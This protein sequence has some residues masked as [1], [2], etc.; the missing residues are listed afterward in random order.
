MNSCL[1]SLLIFLSLQFS[2]RAD[3]GHVYNYSKNGADWEEECHTGTEQSP[4][5]I[6]TRT[7]VKCE[8]NFNLAVY[9]NETNITSET[10]N[11]GTTFKSFGNW[12][13][14]VWDWNSTQYFFD[15][16]QFHFHAPSEHTVNG[17][18]FDGEIHLVHTLRKLPNITYN[19]T[20]TYAVLGI[21]LKINDTAGDHPFFKE[22]DPT[23]TGEFTLNM[24]ALEEIWTPGNFYFYEGGLTTPGCNEVVNWFVV[25]TPI[26]VS[27]KQMLKFQNA[28]AKNISFAGGNGNNRVTMPLNGREVM[29]GTILNGAEKLLSGMALL[30]LVFAVLAW[31]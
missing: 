29:A 24:S 27:T 6:N 3:T 5:N 31:L 30:M 18:F 21:F 2:L 7:V 13:T 19:L 1:F 23:A 9:F 22:Y 17:D 10:E 28:W 14:L 15:C 8:E 11:L 20:R 26:P 4:I 25:D 16:A 12:S